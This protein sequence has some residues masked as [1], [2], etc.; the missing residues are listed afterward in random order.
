MQLNGRH[1][2]LVKDVSTTV[3]YASEIKGELDK[4]KP[5]GHELDNFMARG[6]EVSR[7]ATHMLVEERFG[8]HERDLN[9]TIQTAMQTKWWQINN[10]TDM[11]EKVTTEQWM[12]DRALK[13]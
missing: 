4:F 12:F 7:S 2:A 3:E 5:P 13:I 6:L 10:H 11:L 8:D 1:D 9:G